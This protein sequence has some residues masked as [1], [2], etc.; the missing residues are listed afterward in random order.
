M[1]IQLKGLGASKGTVTGPAKLIL[2]ASGIDRI[3]EGD[4]L[5]TH[6]TTPDF[7]AG[8][9]LLGGIVTDVGGVTCHAAIV[10]REFELPCVVGV[11]AIEDASLPATTVI[12]DG[13]IVTI[14]VQSI[15]GSVTVENAT[16]VR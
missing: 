7:V 4:I 2:D 12:K 3:E 11:K 16:M 9:G 14:D 5:V 10:S 6:M 15:Q 8:F 13:D 1:T